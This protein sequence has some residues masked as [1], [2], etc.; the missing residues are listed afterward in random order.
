MLNLLLIVLGLVTG[1]RVD[2]PPSEIVRVQVSE[3]E[4]SPSVELTPLLR[5]GAVAR[6]TSED[7]SA[8]ILTP[9]WRSY[10]GSSFSGV[11][12]SGSKANVCRVAWTSGGVGVEVEVTQKLGEPND[13]WAARCKEAA[14]DLKVAFPPDPQSF[15][16]LSALDSRK[17]A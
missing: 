16:W 6:I 14:D 2:S 11:S 17:A 9:D 7:G 13:V 5:E 8:R 10:Y 15:A 3:Q 1:F 4:A 12:T